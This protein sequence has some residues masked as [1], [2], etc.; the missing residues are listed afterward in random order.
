VLCIFIL[1]SHLPRD[2]T[3]LLLLS[4][5]QPEPFMVRLLPALR[6]ANSLL[7]VASALGKVAVSREYQP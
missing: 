3:L 5:Q 4:T 1:I 2:A 6:V 7:K